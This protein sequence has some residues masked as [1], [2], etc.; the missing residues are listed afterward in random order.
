MAASACES[1]QRLEN[2]GQVSACAE[3]ILKANIS[4]IQDKSL[5]DTLDVL[6]DFSQL[7]LQALQE[8]TRTGCEVLYALAVDWVSTS[9][10]EIWTCSRPETS[11]E[12]CAT[13][14]EA[15]RQ[16]QQTSWQAVKMQHSANTAVMA[17][18]QAL[19]EGLAA[20]LTGPHSQSRLPSSWRGARF[21]TKQTY[22]WSTVIIWRETQWQWLSDSV[23][24][25]RVVHTAWGQP[26]EWLRFGTTDCNT[27]S[28]LVIPG[29]EY[30]LTQETRF[31]GMRFAVL[32]ALLQELRLRRGGGSLIIVEVGVFLGQLSKFILDHCDFVQ[33]I[34]VDPYLG[35]DGTFPGNFDSELHPE[36]AFHHASKLY[37]SFGDRALLL[38]ATSLEAAQSLPD[39]S[40][41]AV[42]IDG[43]HYYNCVKSDFAAWMPKLRAT[44]ETLVAGHDF[45]PQWP[46]VVRAVQEQRQNHKIVTLSTDW[47][48]WWFDRPQ[49]TTGTH[50]GQSAG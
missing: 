50:E 9:L 32:V 35:A 43:C 33:L 31:T 17:T 5:R 22:Y 26:D 18:V 23:A 21:T 34:G 42:F 41:D 12:L 38:R 28:P 6:Q 44:A 48:F 37:A 19:E 49:E 46:G 8:S 20:E 3:D 13:V 24:A 7:G 14:G 11:K 2:A 39:N 27:E 45:S 47:L 29:P 1:L 4:Q 10:Y 36:V 40:I 25:G 16:T 30:V 15:S